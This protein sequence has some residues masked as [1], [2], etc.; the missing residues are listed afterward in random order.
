MLINCVAYR[1][2]AKLAELPAPAGFS[3]AVSPTGRQRGTLVWPAFE[4]P[5]TEPVV[6]GTALLSAPLTRG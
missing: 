1:D 2:G 3:L 4:A 6:A 5:G